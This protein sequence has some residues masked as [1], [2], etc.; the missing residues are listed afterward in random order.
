MFNISGVLSEEEGDE[1]QWQDQQPSVQCDTSSSTVVA[2]V[3][4]TA[5]H[6][7][8]IS[9]IVHRGDGCSACAEF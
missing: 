4:V 1:E 8:T 5:R 2:Q 3:A 9:I 7:H 6:L